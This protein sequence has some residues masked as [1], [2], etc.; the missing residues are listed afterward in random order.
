MNKTEVYY[1]SGTENSF[2]L[3]KDITERLS[4]IVLA[5]PSLMV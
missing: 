4:G 3:K 2:I 1:F 5:I